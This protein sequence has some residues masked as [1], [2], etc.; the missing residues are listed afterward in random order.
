M[1]S[2]FAFVLAFISYFFPITDEILSP[3]INFLKSV[4]VAAVVV[5]LLIWWGSAHLVLCISFMVVFP[6][7]YENMLTALKTT[8]TKLLEMAKVF[9]IGFVSKFLWI[10]RE[11]YRPYLISALRVSLGMAFKSGIAAEIIGLPAFSIGE[12]LYRDKI[13]LNTAGVFAWIIVILFI[14]FVTEK[15]ILLLLKAISKIPDPCP[16]EGAFGKDKHEEVKTIGSADIWADGIKKS[17]DG[18]MV[19]DC[20]I[21]LK[22]GGV[23]YLN[24]PSGKGKT[25]LLNILAGIEKSD[26]GSVRKARISMVFQDDRLIGS[27]NALR[28]LKLAQCKGDLDK[29]INK[30]LPQRIFKI[31]AKDLSGGERRRLCILRALLH[32]SDILLMDEPF[33][34]LDEGNI[35]KMKECI[36]EHRNGRT[37]LIV[38]HDEA[39]VYEDMISIG[40]QVWKQE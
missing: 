27:A 28:N 15:L 17:Y 14:S 7:V 37:L 9:E 29:E 32:P 25:T 10:Y 22:A 18:D 34:G 8:D 19:I 13:Y 20:S 2:L 40:G 21:D 31:P 33:A 1:A 5:I 23:Y 35:L 36:K 3:F 12:R 16:D 26:E 11:A 38:G 39:D 6:N 24:A 4:P 30:I